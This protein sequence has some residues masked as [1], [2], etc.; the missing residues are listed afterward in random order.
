MIQAKV[1][2]GANVVVGWFD[3][4]LDLPGEEFEALYLTMESG[5]IARIVNY[6]RLT[7]VLLE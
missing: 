5:V 2:V 7:K 4:D 1:D 6:Q 3:E